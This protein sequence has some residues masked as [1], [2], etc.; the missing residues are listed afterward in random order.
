MCVVIVVRKEDT[1]KN[2][3]KDG[4][5][6]ST[7]AHTT[8]VSYACSLIRVAAAQDSTDHGVTN[9]DSN[10]LYRRRYS[11][12][13]P[14]RGVSHHQWNARPQTSLGDVTIPY[15]YH[16]ITVQKSFGFVVTL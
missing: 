13:C 2:K 1:C 16:K 12:G 3:T 7:R 6:I 14:Y 15:M 5:N 11:H 9:T 10:H 4:T 8:D